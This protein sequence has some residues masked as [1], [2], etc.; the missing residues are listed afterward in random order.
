MKRSISR[1]TCEQMY[2]LTQKYRDVYIYIYIYTVYTNKNISTHKHIH[3]YLHIHTLTLS[4]TPTPS[5]FPHPH[6]LIL[7]S[8]PHPHSFPHPPT[9]ILSLTPTPSF[10]PSPPYP[11]SF[12]HTHTHMLAYISFSLHWYNHKCCVEGIPLCVQYVHKGVYLPS[13]GD[14]LRFTAVE[15]QHVDSD[16]PHVLGL[17]KGVELK[18]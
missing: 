14:T 11:H 9:L 13:N 3:T 10:F 6:T 1:Q 7:P 17:A 18:A 16:L 2:I 12:P 5:F 15:V 4:L 8:P